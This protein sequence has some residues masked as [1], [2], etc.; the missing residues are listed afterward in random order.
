RQGQ[1]VRAADPARAD[2]DDEPELQ[3]RRAFRELRDR[4]VEQYIER[5][6]V[7]LHLQRMRSAQ[8]PGAVRVDA[9]RIAS[10][11]RL[12][13]RSGEEYGDHAGLAVLPIDA[14][15][16]AEPEQIASLSIRQHALRLRAL[17]DCG[18]NLR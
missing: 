4:H 1:E 6:R 13:V 14:A 10:R 9:L 11:N 12:T 15:G 17:E 18:L 2:V 5:L 7:A 3:V 16:S 8:M